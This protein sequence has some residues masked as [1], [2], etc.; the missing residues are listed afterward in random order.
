MARVDQSQEHPDPQAQVFLGGVVWDGGVR[1]GVQQLLDNKRLSCLSVVFHQSI[2]S[3]FYHFVDKI[4]SHPVTPV[5][6]PT[7]F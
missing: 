7:D 4:C 1:G 6:K 5:Y 3:S 2:N